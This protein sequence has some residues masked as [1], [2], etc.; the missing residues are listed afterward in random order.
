MDPRDL[1]LVRQVL[2]GDTDAFEGLVA[3]HSRAVYGLAFRITGNAAAAEDAVQETFLRAFRFLSTF[4]QPAE[5]G[6]WLH[7]IAVNAALGQRRAIHPT[8]TFDH[9][10]YLTN[11]VA[12]FFQTNGSDLHFLSHPASHHCLED[13][14][15]D[16][17]YLVP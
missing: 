12:R 13:D 9:G 3:A 10:T 14:A 5:L 8:E 15:T 17:G 1:Q 16:C 6:T 4:D 11:L 7:R 2:A